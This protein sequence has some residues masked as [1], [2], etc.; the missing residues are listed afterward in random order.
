MPRARECRHAVEVA[1]C[2]NAVVTLA[3]DALALDT[4]ARSSCVVGRRERANGRPAYAA[5]VALLDRH[6]IAGATAVLGVDGT[7]H[8]VRQAR[9][10]LRPQR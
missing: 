8:G 10:V 5:V 1:R 3:L 7:A 2:R 9:E 6:G 4:S